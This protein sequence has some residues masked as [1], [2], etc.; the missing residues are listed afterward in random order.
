MGRKHHGFGQ[1]TLLGRRLFETMLPY[2][3]SKRS[4]QYDVMPSTWI[5]VAEDN[6][7]DEFLIRRALNEAGLSESILVAHDGVEVLQCLQRQ[8]QFAERPAGLPAV[9]LLHER[10]P[11]MGGGEVLESIR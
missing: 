11:V 4:D 2:K 10:M 1:I 9:I 3:G 5:L 6:E 7:N 8:G